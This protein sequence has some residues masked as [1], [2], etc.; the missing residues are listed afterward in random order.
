[1]AEHASGAPRGDAN[2]VAM[3]RAA[4]RVGALTAVPVVAVAGLVRGTAGALTAL[5]AVAFVTG[6]FYVTGRSLAWAASKSVT[7]LQAMALG[8]FFVR[9]VLYAVL[10]VVLRPVEAI[11]GP[12]LA[13]ATAVTMIVVLAFEVRFVLRHSE[14]WWVDADAPAMPKRR[15]LLFAQLDGKERA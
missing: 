14:L 15:S 7:A 6:L 12:V 3:A 9:L 8:G 1:M 4:V 2:E 10:I 13:I 11:D 5:A